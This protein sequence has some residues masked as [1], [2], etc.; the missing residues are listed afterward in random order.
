MAK[1]TKSK[2]ETVA[3]LV[4]VY[5]LN[6]LG[7]FE[8]TV[9]AQPGVAVTPSM[10]EGDVAMVRD[11]ATHMILVNDTNN[12][13]TVVRDGEGYAVRGVLREEQIPPGMFFGAALGQRAIQLKALGFYSLDDALALSD[14]DTSAKIR[15]WAVE[16]NAA[17]DGLAAQVQAGTMTANRAL[18]ELP[19]YGGNK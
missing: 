19:V 4:M 11:S 6:A 9:Q 15:A 12:G 7:F 18:A 13:Y 5:D 17:L 8:R 14:A 1:T 16:Y 3:V 2:A 10:L